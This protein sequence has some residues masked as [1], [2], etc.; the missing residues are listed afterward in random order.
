[1]VVMSK[2]PVWTLANFE[3]LIKGSM[4]K[5]GAN[6]WKAKLSGMVNKEGLD[7]MK[8]LLSILEKFTEA[9]RKS[10]SLI[11]AQVCTMSSITHFRTLFVY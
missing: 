5:A 11:D 2:V 10:P 3:D 7:E 9:E 1:M 4:E 6:G 8:K